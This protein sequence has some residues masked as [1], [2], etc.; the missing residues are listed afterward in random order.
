METKARVRI[1]QKKL[2]LIDVGR[3]QGDYNLTTLL[4]SPTP[5]PPPPQKKI[6]LNPIKP[7]LPPPQPFL[8][9]QSTPLL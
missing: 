1:E 3:F 9:T 6:S 8:N 4:P 7:P 2:L 5:P